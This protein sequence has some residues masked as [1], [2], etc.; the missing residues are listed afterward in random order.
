MIRT[1]TSA[2]TVRTTRAD[3]QFFA[4]KS[5]DSR[6][7]ASSSTWRG[8]RPPT[9]TKVNF[10]G[11]ANVIK[12]VRVEEHEIGDFAGIDQPEIAAFADHLS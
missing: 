9:I 5:S 4:A 7:S 1:I 10:S 2:V 8:S 12:R 3:C 6:R 11:V